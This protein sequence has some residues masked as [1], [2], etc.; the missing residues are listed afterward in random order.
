MLNLGKELASAQ[1]KLHDKP[2]GERI[3]SL[4]QIVSRS[5]IDAILRKHNPDR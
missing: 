3:R 2:V 1:V 5:R 4:K